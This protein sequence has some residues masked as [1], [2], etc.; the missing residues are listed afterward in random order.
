MDLLDAVDRQDMTLGAPAMKDELNALETR[1]AVLAHDIAEAPPAAPRLHP[2]LAELYRKKV[3]ALAEALNANATRAEAAE[4][5]RAL[6]DE[7]G[8]VA[9]NG[10]LESEL[11]GALAG[12]LALASGSKNPGAVSSAGL[13]QVTLV[14][15]A[16]L[17]RDRHSLVVAI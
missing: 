4:A 12:I 1:K 16:R 10:K 9:E 6:S 11:S 13:E 17:G 5:I 7:I 2:A 3:A 14:A 15:G 8:L